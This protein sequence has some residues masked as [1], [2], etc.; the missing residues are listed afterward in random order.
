VKQLFKGIG[1]DVQHVR[2]KDPR[3]EGK[4]TEAISKF[5]ASFLKE[6]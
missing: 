3:E 1:T 2:D 5:S 4:I 6:I